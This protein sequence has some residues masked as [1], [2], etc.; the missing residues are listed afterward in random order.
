M[1]QLDIS[2]MIS[3]DE[4][5]KQIQEQMK[6]IKISTTTTPIT[7]IQK[8]LPQVP[9]EKEPLTTSKEEKKEIKLV[10]VK[11][12][13]ENDALNLLIGF[14]Q[15]GQRRGVFNIDESAKIWECINKFKRV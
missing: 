1:E 10:D 7:P 6:N 2:S 5:Q 9:T 11:V 4:L 14:L 12:T 15:L 13:N 8:D 3:M